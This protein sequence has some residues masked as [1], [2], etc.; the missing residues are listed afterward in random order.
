MEPQTYTKEQQAEIEEHF[1]TELRYLSLE[2]VLEDFPDSIEAFKAL[3]KWLSL[4]AYVGFTGADKRISTNFNIQG[5]RK[6][7]KSDVLVLTEEDWD[8]LEGKLNGG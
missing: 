2:H 4:H 3:A 8:K 5:H 6:G 1:R 7:Q